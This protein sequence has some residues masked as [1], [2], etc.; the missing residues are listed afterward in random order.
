MVDWITNFYKLGL[1]TVDQVKSFVACGW[2][3]ADQYQTITG[4]IYTK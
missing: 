2:I 3:T 4:Q 1:Y